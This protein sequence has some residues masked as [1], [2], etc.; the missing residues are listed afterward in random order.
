MQIRWQERIASLIAAGGLVW[1]VHTATRHFRSLDHLELNRDA[2]Y[3]AAFGV[4]LWLHAKWRRSIDH[5][6]V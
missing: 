6:R 4:V 3:V 1:G 2:V 5:S